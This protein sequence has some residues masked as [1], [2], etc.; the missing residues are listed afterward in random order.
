MKTFKGWS[1]LLFVAATLKYLVLGVPDYT[2]I[3]LLTVLGSL[4]AYFQW[5]EHKDELEKL[6]KRCDAVD[7]HLTQL[8]KNDE[9]FKS[10]LSSLNLGQLKN[11]GNR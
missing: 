4:T 6:N 11:V 7:K 2:D 5:K 10:K 9:D 3:G 1:F 8:Y